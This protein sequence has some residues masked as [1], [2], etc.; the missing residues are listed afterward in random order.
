MYSGLQ[1]PPPQE[2]NLTRKGS[3]NAYVGAFNFV[4]KCIALI[5]AAL[6]VFLLF[7]CDI[8]MYK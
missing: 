8:Y 1:S 5:I 6:Y 2:F 3:A 4:C 7:M